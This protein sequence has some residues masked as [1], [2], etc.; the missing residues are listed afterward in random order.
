MLLAT[1]PALG[2]WWGV[3]AF[4]PMLAAIVWRLQAEEQ[5]LGEHLSGYAEYRARVRYRLIPF[6]S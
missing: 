1:P 6:I 2:S 4:F 5:F 3:I